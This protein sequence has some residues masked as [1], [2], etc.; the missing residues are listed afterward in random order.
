M[1][2]LL[3]QPGTCT[4]PNLCHKINW[5]LWSW[6]PWHL[7]ER[8]RQYKA[9]VYS[10][11]YSKQDTLRFA[12]AIDPWRLELLQDKEGFVKYLDREAAYRL[13]E[14]LLSKGYIQREERDDYHPHYGLSVR[15]EYRLRIPPPPP[16]A[17]TMTD[18]LNAG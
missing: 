16:T 13:G 14:E 12:H 8:H 1:S 15:I 2:L 4:L 11:L 3:A 10:V 9:W 7:R 17:R 6:S 5:W 18:A